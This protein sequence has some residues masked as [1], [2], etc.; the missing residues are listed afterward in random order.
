MAIQVIVNH[1]GP[2]PIKVNLMPLA[3]CPCIWRLA[4]QFGQK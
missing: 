4:A 3:I 1:P 2:L